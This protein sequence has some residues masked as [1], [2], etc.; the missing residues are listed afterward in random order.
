M[1]ITRLRMNDRQTLEGQWRIRHASART[2]TC[3]HASA[4]L[5]TTYASSRA[6]TLVLAGTAAEIFFPTPSPPPFLFPWQQPPVS[7]AEK[8]K[9]TGSVSSL[10]GRKRER[11]R[12]RRR[13]GDEGRGGEGF[14]GSGGAGVGQNSDQAAFV[15]GRMLAPFGFPGFLRKHTWFVALGHRNV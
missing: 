8:W 10:Q 15:S 14:A 5:T 12:E 9:L 13:E 1:L 7:G 4:P 6:P 3:T 2:H 11:R